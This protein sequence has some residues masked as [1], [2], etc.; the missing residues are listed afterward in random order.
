[1]KKISR[2]GW[3]LLSI[4]LLLSGVVSYG[5]WSSTTETYAAPMDNNIHD[6]YAET[7][8]ALRERVSELENAVE[9]LEIENKMLKAEIQAINDTYAGQYQ[10]LMDNVSGLFERAAELERENAEL[11]A[12]LRNLSETTQN[13]ENGL[14]NISEIIQSRITPPYDFRYFYNGSRAIWG[15]EWGEGGVSLERVLRETSIIR[16]GAKFEIADM[17]YIVPPIEK[18]KALEEV[19]NWTGVPSRAYAF[20]LYD[21]DNFAWELYGH[22]KGLIPG[23]AFGVAYNDI[24]AFNWALFYENGRYHL[25]ILEP[26]SG[27]FI[28]WEKARELEINGIKLYDG[29]TFVVG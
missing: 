19:I 2:L 20:D 18:Q 11:R 10:L 3:A 13:I 28:P 5:W 12:E 9:M 8:K 17:V 24:H 15:A 27:R 26:Q 7:L 4:G 29:I 16:P 23:L 21:C 22:I 6:N 1:M 14:E 25:Y